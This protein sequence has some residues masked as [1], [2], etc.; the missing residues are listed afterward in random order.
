MALKASVHYRRW[1]SKLIREVRIPSFAEVAVAV[2][3]TAVEVVG[4]LLD[5]LDAPALGG[6]DQFVAALLHVLD[7][8]LPLGRVLLGVLLGVQVADLGHGLAQLARLDE[9]GFHVVELLRR[10]LLLRRAAADFADLYL[11]VIDA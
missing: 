7:V 9:V 11:D 2:G 8:F 3:A 4:G 1:L 5:L 6:L 10:Q